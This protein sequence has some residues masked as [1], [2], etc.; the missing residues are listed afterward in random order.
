MLG[1]PVI[2][3]QGIVGS[4]IE[5]NSFSS[6]VL[7]ATDANCAIPVKNLRN[8]MLA[9]AKGR[10]LSRLLELQYV[11]VTEDL[12]EGDQLVTSGL[13]GKYPAG[14]LVGIIQSVDK[15]PNATFASVLV[16]PAARLD[17]NQQVLLLSLSEPMREGAS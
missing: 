1:Q 12:L 16:T 15:D 11:P 8:G 7:L 2:D 3:D 6:R 13:G 5:S 9:I 14:Y 17:R 10:G 4:I